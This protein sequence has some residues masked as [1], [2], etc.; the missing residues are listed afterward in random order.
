M[1]SHWLKSC[2]YKMKTLEG[3]GRLTQ[4]FASAGN[5]LLTVCDRTLSKHAARLR[6][7]DGTDGL[8]SLGVVA[9]ELVRDL[10][11]VV[12]RLGSDGGGLEC[13]QNSEAWQTHETHTIVKFEIA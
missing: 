6:F 3:D 2:Q 8:L 1:I 12:D 7:R 10:G 9:A 4:S 13:G 5:A 11:A